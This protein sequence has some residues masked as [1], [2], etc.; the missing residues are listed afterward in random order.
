LAS[1][2][3]RAG[4]V[5]LGKVRTVGHLHTSLRW[6]TV[7]RVAIGS[8]STTNHIL[9]DAGTVEVGLA[10]VT[11][12][13][14]IFVLRANSSDVTIGCVVTTARCTCGCLP[15][16][17]CGA[18]SRKKVSAISE[19]VARAII[20]LPTVV[21]AVEEGAAVK[22]CSRWGANTIGKV[23]RGIQ[24]RIGVGTVELSVRTS[25]SAVLHIGA[26]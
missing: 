15:E 23:A 21:V 2:G 12:K 24:A 1:A 4:D 17:R 16:I 9:V 22:E 3:A 13:I 14:S 6:G 7:E 18:N 5:T 26:T 25:A 20:T 19:R 10:D 11:A 8:S